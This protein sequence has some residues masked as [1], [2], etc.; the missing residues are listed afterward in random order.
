[1]PNYIPICQWVFQVVPFL[2]YTIIPPSLITLEICPNEN[3]KQRCYGQHMYRSRGQISHTDFLLTLTSPVPI[4]LS[5]LGSS[6]CI[7]KYITNSVLCRSRN[8]TEWHGNL[9]HWTNSKQFL[10]ISVARWGLADQFVCDRTWSMS[11]HFFSPYL[12]CNGV[13]YEKIQF[14]SNDAN[15]TMQVHLNKELL[16]L[17]FYSPLLGHG[18]FF[19]FLIHTQS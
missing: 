10:S 9:T 2:Q 14:V 1:M 5:K 13:W 12:L 7:H 19:S 18:R 3:S 16:L 6:L 17:W 11:L 15:R 4:F 8:P